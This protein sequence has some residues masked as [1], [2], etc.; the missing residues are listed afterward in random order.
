MSVELT[1]LVCF[2]DSRD[3][4]FAHTMIDAG[5]FYDMHEQVR[6]LPDHGIPTRFHSYLA[7]DEGGDPC[8]GEMGDTDPY[9]NELRMVR[10]GALAGIDYA[11]DPYHGPY[12]IINAAMA[13]VRAMDPN[14]WIVLYWH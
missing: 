11:A 8:Y 3:S 4:N 13:Y 6:A 14:D 1:L 10:A 2:N 12:P 7:T 5:A 9:G